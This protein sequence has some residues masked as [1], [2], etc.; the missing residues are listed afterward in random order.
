[1]MYMHAVL[2][3][4]FL[5]APPA[6]EPLRTGCSTDDQQI[7]TLSAT[8]SIQVQVARS[9]EGPKTCYKV[10]ISRQGQNLTG[11]VLGESLPAVASFVRLREKESREA[12][13]AQARMAMTPPTPKSGDKEQAKPA[14][15]NLPSRFD[16]FSWRD[17]SGKAGSLSGLGG[18]VT[19]VTFW[20]PKNMGSR[21]ELN[22]IV[23]LYNEFHR[24][25]LAAVGVSMD[26]NPEHMSGVLDDANFK[27]PQVPDRTGLAARYHVNPR[28]GETFVLDASHRVIAAGPMGPEL[29]KAVR[30]L[31]AAP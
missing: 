10:A 19:L 23:P 16:D 31:L 26:P 21:D 24:K 9:G 18:R 13:E 28:S 2:L 22:S 11:Y 30:K 1:M 29:E 14:D 4:A 3:F 17:I 20:P 25:G 8:D 12:A 6:V 27:W 15:P 7:A 5:Q